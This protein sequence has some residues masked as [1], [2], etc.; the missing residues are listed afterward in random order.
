MIKALVFDFDGLILDTETPEYRAWVEVYESL[1]LTLPKGQWMSM[2]GRGTHEIV[3]TPYLGLEEL[4]GPIDQEAIRMQKRARFAE[5]MSTETVRPGVVELMDESDALGVKLAVASSSS[6]AWVDPYLTQLGLLDRFAVI[7]CR[8]DVPRAKP[9]PDLYLA[10]VAA[11]GVNVDEAMALEDSP[12]GVAAAKAA[13]L[14][15]IA[16]PNDIT[17]LLDLSAADRIVGSL[18]EVR[19]TEF[20]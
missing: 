11:L 1:G 4:L 12:N 8:D 19:L 10:A 15:C 20:L 13:G 16:S 9:A 2:I 5:L 6:H 18:A 17:K 3:W 7:K 14:Y